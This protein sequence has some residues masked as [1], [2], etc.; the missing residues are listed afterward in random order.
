MK[1]SKIYMDNAAATRM[2][3]RVLQAMTPYFFDTYAVAT[4]EFGYSQGIEAREALDKARYD[5]TGLL[6]ANEDELL[7]TSGETEASNIA[8]KGVAMALGDKKGRHIIV[9]RIE[10]FPV[11]SSARAL[12]R[13]G[14]KVTYINVDKDGLVNTEDLENAFNDETILVS[15]QMPPIPLPAYRWIWVQFL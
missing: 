1:T 7:F 11:L 14:F 5:L 13:Q 6:G 8:L 2:D 12:E 4:S 15:I 3:E 9:S 10:D